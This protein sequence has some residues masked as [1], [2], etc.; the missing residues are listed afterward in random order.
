MATM[1]RRDVLAA[2]ADQDVALASEGKQTTLLDYTQIRANGGTQM[3]AAV[4]E[5]TAAEYAESDERRT[6]FRIA[7]T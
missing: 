5:E 1:Q 4:N 6:E 3:R 7:D 2:R